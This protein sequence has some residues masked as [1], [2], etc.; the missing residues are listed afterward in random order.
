MIVSVALIAS[1][2]VAAL[3]LVPSLVHVSQRFVLRDAAGAIA[4][5]ELDRIR[6][7]TAFYPASGARPDHT[8]ALN[9]SATFTTIAHVHRAFCGS[10]Q[11]ATDVMMTVTDMYVPASDTVTVTVD[12]P[13][14]PCNPALTDRL[15]AGGQLSRSQVAPGTTIAV[16]IGD[17][18]TQ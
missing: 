5:T 14:D 15:A 9:A 2:C 16:P 18:S 10:A 17:P 12:Y 13:R 3:A 4:R 8:Y 1:A 7:A 11:S 6:A